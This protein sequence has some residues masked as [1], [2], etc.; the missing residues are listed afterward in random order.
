MVPCFL[1]NGCVPLL[2]RSSDAGSDFEGS[3][4]EGLAVEV[5][6]G[7]F[8]LGGAGKFDE[9]VGRVAAGVGVC[10]HVD[11]VAV[12]TRRGVRVS[13]FLFFAN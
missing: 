13:R 12:L 10:G 2:G 5:L 3:T 1:V 8:G 11:V 4:E 6:H 7:V 9:T